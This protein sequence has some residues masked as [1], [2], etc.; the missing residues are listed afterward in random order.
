LFPGN[1][2]LEERTRWVSAVSGRDE[3]RIT[4]TFPSIK[5]SSAVLFL[6][7]GEQKAQVVARI[8]GGDKSLPATRVRSD[9]EIVWF[10][11]EAAA[12]A[13]PASSR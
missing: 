9:G 3:P 8:R 11:D 2:V 4:L 7:E 13:L 10:M 12:S 5:S 6:V 1:S